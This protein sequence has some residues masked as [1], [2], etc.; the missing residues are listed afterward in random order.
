MTLCASWFKTDLCQ[1]DKHVFPL[2]HLKQVISQSEPLQYWESFTGDSQQYRRL[3]VYFFYKILHR[4]RYETC[5][6]KLPKKKQKKNPSLIFKLLNCNIATIFFMLE[7]LQ[8]ILYLFICKGMPFGSVEGQ[9]L[10]K[11]CYAINIM[12]TIDINGELKAAFFSLSRNK[13]G[14]KASN[15]TF[16]PN[17]CI[18]PV[19]EILQDPYLQAT[20]SRAGNVTLLLS[21]ILFH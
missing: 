18:S 13:K 21:G 1:L 20:E 14:R 2:W 6:R 11:C 7:T 12:A 15:L 9:P 8:S 5:W 3:S 4:Y 17:F 16:L 19:R 10:G